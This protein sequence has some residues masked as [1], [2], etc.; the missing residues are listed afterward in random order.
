MVDPIVFFVIDMSLRL[1][2]TYSS[3]VPLLRHAGRKLIFSG[4]PLFKFLHVL[5]QLDK[6]SMA[7]VLWRLQYAQLGISG[8]KE[9][10]ISL[11][12]KML[13][14]HDGESDFRATFYSTNIG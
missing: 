9:M 4:T 14:W 10:I 3:H 8:R 7:P 12:R 6:G 11:I 2:T 5:Y 13:H 1:V